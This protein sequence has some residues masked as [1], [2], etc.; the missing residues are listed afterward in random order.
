[1]KILKEKPTLISEHNHIMLAIT[2]QRL[3]MPKKKYIETEKPIGVK[4]LLSEKLKVIAP[5]GLSFAQ[6]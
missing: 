2:I 6:L 3:E 4:T 1:M 5:E